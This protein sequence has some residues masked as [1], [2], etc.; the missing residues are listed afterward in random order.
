MMNLPSTV[1]RAWAAPASEGKL[2]I[3]RATEFS[4]YCDSYSAKSQ[5]MK[6]PCAI[7][8]YRWDLILTSASG[9]DE[10]CSCCN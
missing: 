2:D 9:T 5:V 7:A 3:R 4:P 1:I 6:K 10:K 8:S